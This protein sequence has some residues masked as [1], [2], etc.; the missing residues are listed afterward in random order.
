MESAHLFLSAFKSLVQFAS[1]IV[2]VNECKPGT[3]SARRLV[4]ILDPSPGIGLDASSF[5]HV[6]DQFI[7]ALKVLTCEGHL[8]HPFFVITFKN[9]SGISILTDH[10]CKW[11]LCSTHRRA[12]LI[13][14]GNLPSVPA[15]VGL[16]LTGVDQ[17]D[18]N[19]LEVNI[20][21]LP[22]HC[23]GHLDSIPHLRDNWQSSLGMILHPKDKGLD[24]FDMHRPEDNATSS[25]SPGGHAFGHL[26]HVGIATQKG[27]SLHRVQ[28]FGFDENV[29]RSNCVHSANLENPMNRVCSSDGSDIRNLNPDR[30]WVD[31][32]SF[33]NGSGVHL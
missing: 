18:V 13:H 32:S 20:G 16:A 27:K 33:G 30:D 6:V 1:A 15:E 7:V 23:L 22:V 10:V 11:D 25:N 28:T 12:Q 26:G 3:T 31:G 4:I 21:F 24:P 19:L 14:E 9:V 8:I 2:V 29:S 17:V 5:Q